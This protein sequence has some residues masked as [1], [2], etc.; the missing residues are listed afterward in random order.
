[1][2]AL[3]KWRHYLL[4]KE[5]I[6]YTD[7]QALSFL[8]SQDKISHK[9]MKWAEYMQAYTFTIRHKKSQLNRVVDALSQRLLTVQE[10]K[11]RSIGVDSF[12]D[13]YPDDE[14]LSNAY[15]VC[16][17]YQNHFHSE[18][19]DYTLENGLLFKGRQLCV[20]R[21]SLRKN[22]IQ[23][24]HNGSLSGHFEVNKTQELVQR[25][26]Y[27]PRMNQYVRKYVETCIICQRPRAHLQ[28]L[29]YTN[30]FTYQIDLG[31]ALVWTL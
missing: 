24:K 4:P 20:P 21:G 6:V 3:R 30:L 1:M 27:W 15:E 12:K 29:V 22:L 8:N 14:D 7:N 25:Y 9:H 16:K 10:N 18:F 2:Q 31:S 19:S 23:E 28:M 5:F 17:E 26:Y 11:L 13:L